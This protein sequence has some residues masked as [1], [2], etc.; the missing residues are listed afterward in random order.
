MAY[1]NKNVSTM[2]MPSG[3][4]R[5]GQFPLDMSS[6]YYDMESLEAY[7]TSGAIA[8]VGQIVSLVDEANKK[9]TVYSI[10]NIEGD[11][12]EVGTIPMGDDKSIEVVNGKIA[13]HDFGTAYYEY[14]PEEKDDEGNVTR[15]ASY[16]KVTVSE[17]K[18][19]KA[20]LEPKV[21]TEGGQLVIGWYE[22]NPTT[23]EGV[24]DQVTAVQGTVA[25][26]E[27][28][29]GTPSAEGQEATGLYKEVEDV[30]ADV[31]ELTDSVGSAEDSLSED[32]NTLW[33]NVNDHSI[34]IEALEN[35]EDANTEYHLE[36]DSEAKEIKLVI[37][38]S[39]N[40]MTIDAT[41]FIKDGMLNNVEYDAE[42]N[43]LVFT[44]NTDAGISVDRVPVGDLV[45]VYTAGNG[46]NIVDNAISAVVPENDKYLTV[47]ATGI[48]T[49]GIDDAI[50]T[51]EQAAKDY[52]DGLASDYDAA[53]AAEDV[54]DYADETFA[55]KAY[56]GTIPEG[57]G[58]DVIAY[59]NKKAEET[60]AAAQGGSS[61]TAASVKLALDNYKEENEPKF[62]KLEGIEAGAEVNIIETVK[63]NGTAL[64]VTDK[65]VNIDLSAYA[66][67]T[68]VDGV[69]V[70]A[71][72]GVADAAAAQKTAND[73]STAASN[74]G[75]AITALD[76]RLGTAEGNINKNAQAIATHATEFST[77]KGR[78]DGHDTALNERYTKSEVYTKDEVNAITG[79]PTAGKTLVGMIG[80]V[81]SN[82]ANADSAL[83]AQIATEY[84]A[85]DEAL[86]NAIT[87]EYIK[88]DTA[89]DT[90]LTAEIN[91]KADQTALETEINRAKAA[92][93]A[94]ADE[95]ARVN[96]VLVNA[97][98]NNA[99]ALDSIKESATWINTYGTQATAM[100]EAITAN[101]TAIT[102][103]TTTD[104]PA[105]LA[106]AKGYTDTALTAYKVKDVDGTTLQLTEAGVASV[107]AISTDLLTQGTSELILNGGSAN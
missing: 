3:M 53:G 13:M 6:V 36:Y 73:A 93:K 38:A 51:A 50:A 30:Q 20:G 54:K 67:G 47:D 44:W 75:Q 55:T 92:E 62:A 7:A 95:I 99:E 58:A 91:K 46:I 9:V 106:E 88:A 45:D 86:K 77:L 17:E 74:N 23:I 5:M 94:N 16:V 59:I 78:V 107:K 40:Q 19:W 104:I 42:A 52:A 80:D 79:T 26:L 70:I 28:S 68:T 98:E 32:V 57:K 21:V 72:Q 63:V 76:G 35:K 12:K 81:E 39:D 1:I 2:A 102:K 29:V 8:Y 24:N 48:H 105:A 15:E 83:K 49:K 89:L 37:G 14:V 11:L 87:A 90:K 97:I 34:R 65:A 84:A 27:V 96:G 10:Q 60:L 69:K 41:P 33:A 66:L 4:N 18:P 56:V 103:I 22:P 43:E 64:G 101:T 82:F 61:E 85:A 71:E 31:E 25:D 100:S